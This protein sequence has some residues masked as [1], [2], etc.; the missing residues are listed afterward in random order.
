MLLSSDNASPNPAAQ[1]RAGGV[2]RPEA[3]RLRFP[4]VSVRG[5]SLYICHA[6]YVCHANPQPILTCAMVSRG[7][8]SHLESDERT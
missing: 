1:T 4:P 8:N 6:Q 2:E 5:A 3:P 7:V